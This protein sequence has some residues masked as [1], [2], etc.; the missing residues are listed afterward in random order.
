[1]YKTISDII[2]YGA[3]SINSLF[4]A[5]NPPPCITTTPENSP[6]DHDPSVKSMILMRFFPQGVNIPRAA[7]FP[8]QNNRFHKIEERE[9]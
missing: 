3:L 2:S 4:C 8:L 1:M 9:L 6:D 7:A 5:V